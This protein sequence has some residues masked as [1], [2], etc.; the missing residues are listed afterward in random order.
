VQ[1]DPDLNREELAGVAH[2]LGE[3]VG[4]G[5][6]NVAHCPV[7]LNLMPRSSLQRQQFNQKKPFLVAAVFCLITII[8]AFGYFNGKVAKEKEGALENL[9]QRLQPLQANERSLEQSMR[10]L[11]QA[12]DIAEQYEIWMEERFYWAG[13]LSQVRDVLQ[14]VE[15]KKEED[16]KVK[17]GLWVESL[18]PV[19]CEATNAPAG[20]PPGGPPGGGPGGGRFGPRSRGPRP[21]AGP[22]KEI[23]SVT[24]KCRGINLQN[25]GPSANAEAAYAVTEAL[26][27]SGYFDPNGVALPGTIA[28]EDFTF[29]FEL[30]AKLKRPIKL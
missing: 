13:V 5:L 23:C 3:V 22:A 15:A 1:I 20:A 28:V 8:F 10:E 14:A 18:I 25:T 6:R 19:T 16:L 26:K 11:R 30:S 24:L 2:M 27:K 4:L 29:V 17:T 9:K 7:E 21:G 12:Q